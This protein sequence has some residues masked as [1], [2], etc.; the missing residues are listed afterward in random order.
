MEIIQNTGSLC[1]KR[2]LSFYCI[3]VT[4]WLLI[5]SVLDVGGS[6]AVWL[7]PEYRIIKFIKSDFA[8]LLM[9]FRGNNVGMFS[10]LYFIPE[11]TLE[12][13]KAV[14]C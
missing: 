3:A 13:V 9:V 1:Y 7:S 11:Y 10:C 12:I 8:Y 2:R 14:S 5:L 4:L 6:S